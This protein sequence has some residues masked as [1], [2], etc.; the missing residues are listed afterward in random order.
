MPNEVSLV[1]GGSFSRCQI[2]GALTQSFPGSAQ[3][4]Q[5]PKNE[6]NPYLQKLLVSL[7]LFSVAVKPFGSLLPHWK[8]LKA[9]LLQKIYFIFLLLVFEYA[10]IA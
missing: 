10:F 6:Y 9:L 3:M 2:P 4:E 5:N 1:L 8:H 7:P